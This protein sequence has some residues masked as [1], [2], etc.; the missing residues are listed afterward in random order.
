MNG[1]ETEVRY[2]KGIGEKRAKLLNRLSIH[3]LK[4][5]L[6]Y[7]PRDYED[8]SK[9]KK[10]SELQF[11]ES[12]CIK[13]VLATD[14]NTSRKSGGQTVLK[15]RVFDD[16]GSL[17]ITYFNQTY[18]KNQLCKGNEYI[19]FGK[20]QGD[21]LRPE[22]INPAFEAVSKAGKSTG[23]IL[24]VYPMI[25]GLTRSI[26][27]Q[28]VEAALAAGFDELNDDLPDSLRKQYDLVH[29]KDAYQNI[30]FP[31]S[32]ADALNARKRF[33]FEELFFLSIG[34]RQIK[35]MR[36]KEN[37]IPLE[38]LDLGVFFS[39]LGFTLTSAQNKAINEAV[40]DMASG[41]LMNRLIQGD[42]GSGK[43]AVATACVY[44]VVKNGYQAALMTPT[45]ILAEQHFFRLAPLFERFS[46]RTAL[47]TGS[48]SSKDKANI[49]EK[50]K[51][52]EIDL[53]IG[54]HALIQKEVGFRNLAL[55][56][57]DEQHRFGVNQRTALMTKGTGKA[58][59]HTLVMS[60]TPNPRTLALI[61]YGD[62]DVSIID[63]L[64]PGRKPVKTALRGNLAR[65]KVYQFLKQQIFAG[66]QI[67]IVCP[68][69]DENG[70]E[71]LKAVEAY[72]DE[73]KND[74][75]DM[76][77]GFLHGRMKP[78]KK[79]EI[80][81]KFTSGAMKILVS[82]TVIEVG[83]D[84]PNATIMVIENAERFGL[85]QLHQLRGRVGR[86]DDQS[87]CIL[88]T[89]SKNEE[90]IKRLEVLCR[91]NDGFKI[92]EEDLRLRGPGDF[93]GKRQ[94]GLPDLKIANLASNVKELKDAQEAA[95]RLLQREPGLTHPENRGIAR[96][97][98][99]LFEKNNQSGLLN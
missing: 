38:S 70:N 69:V 8:R 12:A 35:S 19:F 17:G 13:A 32:L 95:E 56:I 21:F 53:L 47:L 72:A 30:H 14:L 40:L 88:F 75:A 80:M 2:V 58:L 82:T 31:K 45:T 77:I 15:F 66:R 5:F 24:P 93:F 76:E 11:G 16:T 48:L 46:I 28:G 27:I 90:T 42:V 79:E 81:C 9:L 83:I 34:L 65:K 55:V 71:E 37:G 86:G 63:E 59:A 26:I 3:T 61:L 25:S 96:R 10:I 67:Y 85:S 84:V 49:C 87:Y 92:A 22:L 54:T 99:E 68:L 1:L 60:A 98:K 97:V 94:H 6:N 18:V 51:N 33:I 89:E 7:F 78:S 50:A 20:I 44:A 29:A 62:L 43:T 23:R 41:K 74:F 4:D 57:T 36:Q 73:L 39:A 91:T 52:G 64:P